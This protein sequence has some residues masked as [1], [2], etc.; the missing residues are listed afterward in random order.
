MDLQEPQTC[1]DESAKQEGA[2]SNLTPAEPK[3]LVFDTETTGL[4]NFKLPADDPSQ[5][6]LASA[7]FIL[8]DADGTE[9]SRHKFFVRPDGWE[10]P[11]EAG[12]VNGLTN[13]FLSENGVPVA[14]VLDFYSA[15]IGEGLI[16]V[17]FN[18]QF[19]CKMMRAE[20]RRA[21]KP[22]LFEL[23][24]NICVMRGLAPYG[25]EGLAIKGG[26]VKLHVA[27]DHFGIVNEKAHDAMGD[28]EAA[29][30]LLRRLVAD[31]RLPE[32]KVHLAKAS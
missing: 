6:H 20:L 25:A 19:D 5:P 18:A 3:F 17:A 31:N 32:A 21:G 30:A 15:K 2:Q 13:E 4:F 28:A 12:S 27:C 24:N 9:L 23:T 22:D 10:M 1:A 14:E 8:A 7:A 16:A 26:F 11:A 29:H